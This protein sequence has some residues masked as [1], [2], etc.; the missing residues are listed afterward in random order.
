[1]TSDD[2]RKQVAV[3]FDFGLKAKRQMIEKNL[4]RARKKCPLCGGMV[5]LVLAG[6]KQHLHMGCPD[7]GGMQMME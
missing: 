2:F 5:K 6:K 3:I 7:C 4:T 1:M